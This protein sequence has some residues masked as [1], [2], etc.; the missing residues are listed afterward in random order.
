MHGNTI[1]QIPCAF[2]HGR[3]VDPFEIMSPLSTCTVCGGTGVHD[4]PA[5]HVCCTFCRG[6]GSDK[7]FRC[8]ACK[9][10]GVLKALDG[11]TMPCPEC[12]GR[13]FS[14][15]SGLVCLKCQGHGVVPSDPQ[16]TQRA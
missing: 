3:G 14:S 5:D 4:V 1:E 15:S 10:T 12:A 2:C 16:T 6:T 9:G 11:P 8:P 7:T 13:S